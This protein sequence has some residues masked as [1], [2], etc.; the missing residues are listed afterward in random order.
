MTLQRTLLF[1]VLWVL[2]MPVLGCGQGEDDNGIGAADSVLLHAG[3]TSAVSVIIP[4][5][6]V[7]DS[8]IG[9]GGEN[10]RLL[11]SVRGREVSLSAMLVPG[12][13]ATAEDRMQFLAS[14]SE[15]SV[16]TRIEP[17]LGDLAGFTA[18][19]YSRGETS[20]VERVWSMGSGELLVLEARSEGE[21]PGILLE[22]I[23]TTLRCAEVVSLAEDERGVRLSDR[24]R[25]EIV[26]DVNA[27]VTPPPE[28][29]HRLRVRVDPA[30]RV[31]AVTDTMLV[32]FG[33]TPFD[34]SLTVVLPA[35]CV[36]MEFSA[37]RGRVAVM[38][39]SA[40]CT[41]D[42]AR[43]FQGVFAG[44]W[45]GFYSDSPDSIAGCG[46]QIRP[47]CSFQCG[48]WFYPGASI[49]ANYTLEL[50]VPGTG[51]SVYAPLP[52]IS[53]V[54][55]D[56]TLTVTFGS[57]GAGLRG[58]I[59]WATGGF[60]T[61]WIAG[62][63]SAFIS[64]ESDSLAAPAMENADLLASSIWSSLG[65]EGARLDFV[66]V[67]SLDMPV[68]LLGPG[69]VFVSTDVLLSLQGHADWSDFFAAGIPVRETS[70]AAGAARALLAESTWLAGGL[71][72]SLSA[73]AVYRFVS[74]GGDGHGDPAMMEAFLKYYLFETRMSGGTEYALADPLLTGSPLAGPVLMGK[75]PMVIEFL[76]REIPAFGNALRRALGN[77]RHSGDS[78]GRLFSQMGL[79]DGGSYSELYNRWMYGPG[80]P[81]IRVT[82][83]DSVSV[84]S[85]H[86]DQLQPGQEFPLGSTLDTVTVFTASGP[87]QV[88][89]T[90]LPASGS[91][92]GEHPASSGGV[93]GID[94]DPGRVLPADVVYIH[95]EAH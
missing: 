52:E 23:G 66:V 49:P 72:A 4:E 53:R 88:G 87:M 15:D 81:V 57:V 42:S 79:Y 27:D 62:G 65:F 39:D 64:Y 18:V 84:L 9:S 95:S 76:N 44:T 38:G 19:L 5:E 28:L 36:G 92:T 63:R 25:S 48:M 17:P 75:G 51:Y 41:A 78:F 85:L 21:T 43:H 82:W 67:R 34:S 60:S 46:L 13:G 83:S 31:T 16:Y 14:A 37:I 69:C 58:P 10:T 26:S 47:T 8:I 40:V 35:G 6:A 24:S 11:L 20:V 73:W 91:F 77:L 12:S 33:T 55:T 45:D 94:I 71:R 29:T 30:G 70:I 1:A 74:D 54:N 3:K 50:E 80:V 90:E 68:F 56:S 59:A 32:N 61:Q 7:R 86:V 2:L 93:T 22:V 89:M